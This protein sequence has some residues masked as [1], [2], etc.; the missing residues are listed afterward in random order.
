MNMEKGFSSMALILIIAAIVLFGGVKNVGRTGPLFQNTKTPEDEKA[1]I[2]RKIVSTQREIDNLKQQ[3][4][5]EEDKKLQSQYKGMVSL[6]YVNRSTSPAQEYVTIRANNNKDPIL[7]TGW[8]LKSLSTNNQV[9]IPKAT[10]LFF[11]GMVNTEDPLYLSSGETLYLVTGISPN[12]ASFKVNKC[13]GYLGQFQTFVPYLY[14]NCPAPRYEDASS[15]PKIVINDACLDYIESM[16]QCRIQTDPTP[17]NWSQE[18]T[19]FIYN[20]I[21]YPSCIKTHKEDKDFYLKEWR[22]YL[23]RSESIWKD[24]RE[25]IVLYDNE[26]KIVDTLKY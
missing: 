5:A 26:G 22:V 1:D 23:K 18:C 4:Q 20:K 9:T 2:E 7:V 19:N 14:T 25:T 10:Y 15:I 8:T 11:T 17:V 21:N 12:G 6:S 16:A 24:R 3:I 13:S